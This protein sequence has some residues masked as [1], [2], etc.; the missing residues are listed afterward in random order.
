MMIHA[1]RPNSAPQPSA[2]GG[3][4]NAQQIFD[5]AREYGA[6]HPGITFDLAALVRYTRKVQEMEMNINY[7]GAEIDRAKNVELYGDWIK[8]TDGEGASVKI[9]IDVVLELAEFIK[10]QPKADFSIVDRNELLQE[11]LP[12][13]ERLFGMT[14]KRQKEGG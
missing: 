14:F 13:I 1:V 5:L 12:K 7:D 6:E 4:M 2:K 9:A 3:S 10:E 11:L 8:F